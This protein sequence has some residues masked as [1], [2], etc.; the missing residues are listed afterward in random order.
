MIIRKA[1]LHILDF[2]SDMCIFSQKELD[3][4]SDE[5]SPFLEKHIEKSMQDSAQRKGLFLDDSGL[6]ALTLAY[7]NQEI[8]FV[9]VGVKIG[10]LL[11]ETVKRSDNWDM[12]DLV[13][14]E[15]S[16]DEDVYWG[17][18]ILTNKVAY[19]HQV[20]HEDDQIKNQIIR[21]RAILPSASQKLDCFGFINL[22]NLEVAF[23][24]KKRLIDGQELFILQ[25]YI[26][27]CTSSLSSREVVKKVNTIVSKV[28]EDYGHNSAVVVSKAKTYLFENAETSSDLNPYELGSEVFEHDEQMRRAFISEV[29][30][31]GIP[32]KVEV[33]KGYALRAGSK[34]KIKTDTGIEIIFPADYFQNE[35]YLEFV[36]QPDGTISIS[37]KNI[38]KITNSN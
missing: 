8:S 23:H 19:T 5:V 26:L 16:Y 10:E 30:K 15:F 9:D 14:V 38:G 22:K 3:I 24:D 21:H 11:F 34:H 1:V 32:T 29:R 33:N 37:L 6:K 28:A 27:Q 12:I 13:F 7:K 2:H 36:N 20:I 35:N 4:N 25:E 17:I 31:E 18:L